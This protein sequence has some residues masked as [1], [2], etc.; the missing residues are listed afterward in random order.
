VEERDTR[1]TNRATGGT[2][3][4]SG[5]DVGTGARSGPLQKAIMEAAESEKLH[6]TGKTSSHWEKKRTWTR[7]K[8]RG[9]A[10]EKRQLRK[11]R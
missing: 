4:T 9:H 8:K 10:G 6:D 5:Y 2:D 3:N 1:W 11:K 7:L